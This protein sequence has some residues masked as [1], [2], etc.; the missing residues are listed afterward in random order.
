[1]V[2]RALTPSEAAEMLGVTEQ[3][4]AEWRRHRHGPPYLRL[5]HR[6][7]RYDLAALEAWLEAREVS[8]AS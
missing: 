4:L 6:T 7:V 1:M 2:T 5:G 3:T 8:H